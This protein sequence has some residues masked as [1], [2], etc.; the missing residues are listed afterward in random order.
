MTPEDDSQLWN[1]LENSRPPELSRFFARNVI[2][3]IREQKPRRFSDRARRWILGGALVPISGVAAVLLLGVME[4]R[5]VTITPLTTD[6]AIEV[7]GQND[8]ADDDLLT[9]LDEVVSGDDNAPSVDQ[10]IL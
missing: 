7:A 10:S 8:G 9:D 4:K 1:L 5:P 3:E 2:R 6:A